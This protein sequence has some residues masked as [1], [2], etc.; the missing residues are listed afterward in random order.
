MPL[1]ICCFCY[2]YY[3]Q[4]I[5]D[6]PADFELQVISLLITLLFF[7]VIITIIAISFEISYLLARMLFPSFSG[8][9]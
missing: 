3:L 9:T 6:H 2:Y 5:R 1:V 8:A 4:Q 7:S